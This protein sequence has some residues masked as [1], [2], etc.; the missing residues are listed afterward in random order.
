MKKKNKKF[1]TRFD[2]IFFTISAILILII[3][4]RFQVLTPLNAIVSFALVASAPFL[5]AYIDKNHGEE[6][7]FQSKLDIIDSM[8]EADLAKRISAIYTSRGF[9]IEPYE[10]E[11]PGVH[12]I[13]RRKGVRNGETFIERGAVLVLHTDRLVDISVFHDFKKD[14]AFMN[15][16]QGMIVTN[17]RFSP[18]ILDLAN[19]SM[20][21]LWGRK[22]LREKFNL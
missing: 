18:E 17:S 9:A 5:F 7:K 3:G 15:C 14:L 19:N 1:I 21:A 4:L 13:C 6:K 8:S 20:I 10:S 22:E 16:T 11:H 12:M 2:V